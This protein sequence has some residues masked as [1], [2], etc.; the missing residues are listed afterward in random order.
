MLVADDADGGPSGGR[1]CG[2]VD[3]PGGGTNI[4]EAKGALFTM[5]A[6]TVVLALS[7]QSA[8]AAPR[9]PVEVRRVGDDGLSMKLSDAVE[10]EFKASPRFILS[11]GKRSGTLIVT[12]PTNVGWKQF[13]KRMQIRY[14][15]EFSSIRQ[16]KLGSKTGVCW[17]DSMQDCAAQV[18]KAAVIAAKRLST[19]ARNSDS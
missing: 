10:T 16:E 11:S 17:E 2:A 7:F 3:A 1:S 12:I 6:A 14:S 15:V 4:Y 5:I 18:A 8:W 9:I 19:N 13:G